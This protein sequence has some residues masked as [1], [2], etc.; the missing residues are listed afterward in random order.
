MNARPF[1]LSSRHR[2]IVYTVFAVLFVSG[3][4]WWFAD[5]AQEESPTPVAW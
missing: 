2:W 4:A 1:Q 5:E 3:F